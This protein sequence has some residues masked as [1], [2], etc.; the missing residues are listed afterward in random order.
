MIVSMV[1]FAIIQLPKIVDSPSGTRVAILV[2]LFVT[3][4]FLFGYCFYQVFQPWIQNRRFEYLI[5][6]YVD[7]KLLRLLIRNGNPNVT[8]MKDLFHKVDK[9]ENAYI[10]AAELR[11]L[12][13]GMK[14]EEAGSNADKF[15]E[16]IMEGFDTS[17]GD[18]ARIDEAEFVKGMLN[19]TS[20]ATQSA[21]THDYQ[22][23]FKFFR[24]GNSKVSEL[25]YRNKQSN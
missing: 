4:V 10:S 14:L 1:P 2:S 6:K 8:F 9:N 12:I 18:D 25:D 17:A 7:D 15:V 16:K 23:G 3:T 24:T 13:L 21:E 5:H 20:D 19:Y 11:V 22:H